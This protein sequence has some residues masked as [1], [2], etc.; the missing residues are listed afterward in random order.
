[1]SETFSKGIEKSAVDFQIV[2]HILPFLKM[3]DNSTEA[4]FFLLLDTTIE[5]VKF[6]ALM[7]KYVSIESRQKSLLLLLI[8]INAFYCWEINAKANK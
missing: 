1:M 6:S 4:S 5:L 8:K 2:S 3:L 7:N